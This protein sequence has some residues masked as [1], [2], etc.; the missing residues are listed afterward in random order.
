MLRR[1][2]LGLALLGVCASP[3]WGQATNLFTDYDLD[4]AAAYVFC[5]TT[6]VPDKMPTCA[7]GIADEDGWIDVSRETGKHIGIVIDQIGVT[8]GID[9]QIQVRMLEDTGVWSSAIILTN[10]INKT[11]ADTDN[12]VFRIP[13]EARQ[14]RVGLQI[15]TADDGG[16]AI[17]EDIDVVY[18][19]R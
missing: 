18:N 8:G 12:Q 4:N 6:D 11:T 15:G 9:I 7:T 5:D 17:T 3:V 10:L 2:L 16:D 1:I 14:I 19:A 13:D